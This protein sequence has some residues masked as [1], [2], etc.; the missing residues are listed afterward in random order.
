MVPL[1]VL[2]GLGMSAVD[3]GKTIMVVVGSRT[4]RVGSRTVQVGRGSVI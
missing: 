3:D 1:T 4:V 2:D